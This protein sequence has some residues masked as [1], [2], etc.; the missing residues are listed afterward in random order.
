MSVLDFSL[1]THAQRHADFPD[2]LFLKRFEYFMSLMELYYS[3]NVVFLQVVDEAI[4]FEKISFTQC[5][6][7]WVVACNLNNTSCI[8]EIIR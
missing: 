5:I 8:R 1:C 7:I 3:F 4:Q 2:F 6:S